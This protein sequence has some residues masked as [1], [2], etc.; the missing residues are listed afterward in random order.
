MAAK[1]SSGGKP[2]ST[3][4]TKLLNA[5]TRGDAES[6]LKILTYSD[7][8][9]LEGRNDVYTQAVHL[10]ASGGHTQSIEYLLSTDVGVDCESKDN[11][12]KTWTPLI[13]ASAEGHTQTVKMLLANGGDVNYVSKCDDET[14]ALS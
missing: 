8:C 2:Q 14:C 5:A 12:R 1:Q 10:A 9:K 11:R 13:T 7:R 3:W 4:K 6:V